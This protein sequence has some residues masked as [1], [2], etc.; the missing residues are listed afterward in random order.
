MPAESAMQVPRLMAATGVE[1]EV[2]VPA[3]HASQRRVLIAGVGNVLRGDDGFGPAVI[4]ALQEAALPGDVHLVETG[5]GGINLVLELLDGY[6]DLILVDAVDRG[7]AAGTLFILE[8]EV[9]ALETFSPL[10]QHELATDTHQTM[11]GRIL[12]IA[13][14]AGVLPATIRLVGCQPGETEDFSMAL[15]PPV[16]AAVPTAVAAICAM[17]GDLGAGDE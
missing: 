2:A 10:E 12:I 14:A 5:I 3:E 7:G 17:L 4:A 13:R 15:T 16:Q 11:P 6:T 1:Q 9:P 8:P